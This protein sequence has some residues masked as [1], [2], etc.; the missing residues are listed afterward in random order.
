MGLKEAIRTVF[1]KYGTIQGR[2]R[3]S[4]YWYWQ[5]AIILAYMLIGLISISLSGVFQ[6]EETG[7]AVFGILF[8]LLSIATMIPSITLTVRRLHD[9]NKS[10]WWY[11]ICLVP[12]LGGI[13]LFIFTLLDSTPGANKYGEN[14]KGINAPQQ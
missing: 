7:G 13:V 12:Y 2:A 8:V 1:K 5:L 10:G 11:F 4:E 9:I 6:N 14:P 3:R